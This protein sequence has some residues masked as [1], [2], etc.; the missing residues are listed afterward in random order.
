MKKY[1]L[2]LSLLLFSA[3]SFAQ[4]G[5]FALTGKDNQNISFNDFRTLDLSRGTSGDPIFGINSTPK[6]FSESRKGMISE[7]KNSFANSQA[8]GMAALAY[9]NSDNTLVYM[10]MFSSNVYILNPETKEAILLENPSV[11]I[12]PCDINS[13]ITRMTTGYDG[14]VYAMNNSG[15]Q[16]MQISKKNGQYS[17]TNLGIVKDD[18]ANGVNS[19][20][21]VQT[22]FGGDM[23]SDAQNDLYVFAAFGNIFKID[24]RNLT[25][26][27]I[28]KITGLPENYSVNGAAVNENG[29]VVIASAK[30]LPLYEVNMDNL[31]ANALNNG[32]N[33]PI[34][35]LASK[36]FLNDKLSMTN[37]YTGID[38]YPTKVTEQYFNVRVQN[39]E[40]KGNARVEVF[41]MEGQKVQDRKI[42]L[43]RG[44]GE[45]KIDLYNALEGVYI[46]NIT[47]DSGKIILHT[48]ILVAH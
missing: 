37:S 5:F 45:D 29:K 17:V 31:Q 33:L 43:I 38:I 20:T 14:N 3:Q 39:K 23:I 44:N 47:D 24:A 27:F 4:Q 36:Y 16:F 18:V 26:K 13:H 25:A 22:G 32:I 35:D 48:K 40:V 46:V 7:D 21:Q 10:P 30:G 8:M 15:T 11:K 41:N 6:V 42:A 34:Y 12:T 28:G 9:N 19:F 2:P 1:L